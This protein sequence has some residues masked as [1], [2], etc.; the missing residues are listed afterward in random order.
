MRGGDG[1]GARG[2]RTCITAIVIPPPSGHVVVDLNSWD[3][4]KGPPFLLELLSCHRLQLVAV[5][6]LF[7]SAV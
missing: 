1:V 2:G 4:R 3:Y 6:L 7:L 5:W